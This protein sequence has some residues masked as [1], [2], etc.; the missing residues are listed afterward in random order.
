MSVQ[1]IEYFDDFDPLRS[2]SIS[3]SQFRR[4]LSLLGLSKLG[5]HDLQDA[6]FE[7]L[8]DFYQNPNKEDQVMWKNFMDDIES[9]ENI[10]KI[11]I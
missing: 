4:G 10:V 5:H 3:K 7:V 8:I 1:V 11:L 9:G 2:G 6:Q